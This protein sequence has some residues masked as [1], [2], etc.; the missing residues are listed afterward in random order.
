[1]IPNLSPSCQADN[2][3]QLCKNERVDVM[4]ITDV[5]FL[6]GTLLIILGPFLVNMILGIFVAGFSFIVFGIL[7][8]FVQITNEIKKE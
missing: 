3:R 6:I 2:Q 4:S 5:M 7:L 1:M 8:S